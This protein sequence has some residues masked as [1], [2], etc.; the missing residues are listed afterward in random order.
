MAGPA[1]P[2]KF[3]VVG[4]LLETPT[5]LA[6]QSQRDN[7]P[8]ISLLIRDDRRVSSELPMSAT[9]TSS[10]VRLRQGVR[11]DPYSTLAHN[12]GPTITGP[13]SPAHYHRPAITSQPDPSP[14]WAP[15]IHDLRIRWSRPTC[16]GESEVCMACYWRL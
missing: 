12:H 6:R 1:D 14:S 3:A 13:L 15:P 7:G 2:R 4:A 10:T 9:G 11:V 5:T 8:P 16:E